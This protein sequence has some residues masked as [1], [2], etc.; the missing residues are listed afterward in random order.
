MPKISI[1]IPT[2][3]SDT[4]LKRC[5]DSIVNQTVQDFEI[6][7]FDGWSTDKT[8]DIINSYDLE[9]YHIKLVIEEDSWPALARTNWIK[10]AK[11]KYVMF[12]DSDDFIDNDYI[13]TFFN[14]IEKS[15]YNMVI[16]W[17][18]IYK[19]NRVSWTKTFIDDEFSKY[20]S[21]WPRWRIIRRSFLIENE[22]YFPDINM[23]EDV[24]FNLKMYNT[25]RKI[26]IIN[27]VWYCYCVS[28]NNSM[29]KT[30]H[31]SFDENFV[32]WLNLIKSIKPIDINNKIILEYCIIQSCICYL[33]YSWKWV[34]SEEFF[35]EYKK[36]FWWLKENIPNYRRN[37]YISLNNKYESFLYRLAICWFIFLDKLHLVPLFSKVWCI[38]K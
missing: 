33:L 13:E 15:D 6:L 10:I 5:L 38:W 9:K 24:F 34:S 23:R 30:I 36:L 11:W 2:Y 22:L 7:I 25:T 32:K 26:K 14:K 1:I 12:I 19:D 27:Y 21:V 29:T 20:F 31:K 17:Y 4:Y 3:N 37:K 18:K 8:H 35:T 28:N 16:G